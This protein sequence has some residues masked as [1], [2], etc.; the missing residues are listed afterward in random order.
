MADNYRTSLIQTFIWQLITDYIIFLFGILD[1]AKKVEKL[2]KE[3][4]FYFSK[5][6][7][8]RKKSAKKGR[9]FFLSFNILKDSLQMSF[10]FFIRCSPKSIG[11][12]I[13]FV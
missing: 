6:L 3:V 1:Q 7:S 10:F 2:E 4:S 11:D 8:S 5:T 13:G 12:L 9:F